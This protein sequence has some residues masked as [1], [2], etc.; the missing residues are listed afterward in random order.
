MSWTLLRLPQGVLRARETLGEGAEPVVLA[1]GALSLR[2]RHGGE[3]LRLHSGGPR[4][5]LKSLFQEW[6]VPPWLRNGW[7]LVFV[8]EQLALVPGQAVAVEFR[9]AGDGA[10]MSFDWRPQTFSTGD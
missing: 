9:V 7:P 8:G 10:G 4:R 1:D 2:F 6:R 3:R 5:A